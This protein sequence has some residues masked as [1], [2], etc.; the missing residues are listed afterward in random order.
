MIALIIALCI[1]SFEIG[2]FAGIFIS[3]KLLNKT[4]YSMSETKNSYRQ[5]PQGFDTSLN[6]RS[7]KGMDDTTKKVNSKLERAEKNYLDDLNFLFD[8]DGKEVKEDE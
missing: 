1:F 5:S 4:S 3:K 6:E 8:F 7:T 2:T